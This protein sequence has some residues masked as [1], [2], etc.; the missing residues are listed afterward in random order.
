MNSGKSAEKYEYTSQCSRC[1][2]S[3]GPLLELNRKGHRPMPRSHILDRALTILTIISLVLSPVSTL[4]S[5][6][7]AHAAAVDPLTSDHAQAAPAQG[8]KTR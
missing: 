1:P 8:T 4:F 2:L 3:N 7:V 5:P 6:P